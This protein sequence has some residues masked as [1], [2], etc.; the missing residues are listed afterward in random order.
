MSANFTP[1]ML[2]YTGQGPFRYWCQKVLPLVY[3]D[4]LSY[5]EVLNKVTTYLN[6]TISDVA[7]METNVDNLAIAFNNLQG[8]VNEHIDAIERDVAAFEEYVTTYL[9]NLD[10]QEEINTKLDAMASNGTLT[11]IIVSAVNPE[12]NET[13]MSEAIQDWLNDNLTIPD[14]AVA[15]DNSLSVSGL[16]ADAL[17][18]GLLAAKQYSATATYSKGDYAIYNGDLKRANV[19]ITSGEVFTSAHWDSV[20]LGEKL[21]DVNSDLDYYSKN[22]AAGEYT[23]L[24]SGWYINT[25]NTRVNGGASVGVCTIW[26]SITGGHTYKLWKRTKTVFRCGTGKEMAE[27]ASTIP[28]SDMDYLAT[29]GNDELV[30]TA[31]SDDTRLYIQLF[32]NSDPASLKSIAANIGSLMV[33][34]VDTYVDK[35]LSVSGMPADAKTVGDDID[36]I[37]S[38]ISD[39]S[40]DI[41]GIEDEI[42]KNIGS[43]LVFGN[44]GY[45]ETPAVGST[46]SL[47][48]H[49][50]SV[51]D[52]AYATCKA[53][54]KFILNGTRRAQDVSRAY[55]F[56]DEEL[57]CLE[58][59]D[60]TLYPQMTLV[61]FVVTA[62]DDGYIVVN[63]MNQNSDSY[64][65][66]SAFDCGEIY[67]KLIRAE[68]VCNDVVNNVKPTVDELVNHAE[69]AYATPYHDA[70]DAFAEAVRMDIDQNT[71]VIGIQT[72]NHYTT[73]DNYGSTQLVYARAMARLCERIGAD[74]IVNLGDLINSDFDDLLDD[75]YTEQQASASADPDVNIDRIGHLMEAYR[76]YVPFEYAIA[77]HERKPWV[78]SAYSVSRETVYGLCNRFGRYFNETHYSE[79]PSTYYVDFP[80]Q[81]F[82]MIILDSTDGSTQTSISSGEGTFLVDAATTNLPAG[83][84]CAIFTHCPFIPRNLSGRNLGGWTTIA[85]ALN[86]AERKDVMA[87]F[88]G[89]VHEDNLIVPSVQETYVAT[90]T[91]FAGYNSYF[92]Q[93]STEYQRMVARNSV[94]TDPDWCADGYKNIRQWNTVTEYLIDVACIHVDTGVINVHR[95]GAG[96]YATRTYSIVGGVGTASFTNW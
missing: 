72:D 33:V 64:T 26:Y 82:R 25:G 54:D 84:K 78:D 17:K 94:Y 69:V 27:G 34:D 46:G 43:Y 11:A 62:P 51:L 19:N 53:G 59:Y 90:A 93:F 70:E 20:I 13:Y 96:K 95:F 10:V 79:N 67:D 57:K 87:Y 44:N 86:A 91:Q 22:I 63:F 55:A 42:V 1:E 52:Y 39:M 68:D 38:D 65:P 40:S 49:S 56:L 71:V 58:R 61:N 30:V 14:E 81:K 50:I 89:H 3:D 60:G 15:V 18:T 36:E 32:A 9:T 21:E 2:G 76:S 47:T 75:G 73:H 29:A 83:Y 24:E 12:T 6:N 16:A 88:C 85:S 4:S 41:D 37:N 23:A 5:Y 48:P 92:P 74:A 45:L 66:Y 35:S 80:I 8:Y 31:A 77:H 28:L 7:N